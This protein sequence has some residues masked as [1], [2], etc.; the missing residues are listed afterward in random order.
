MH[1]GKCLGVLHSSFLVFNFWLLHA[2]LLNVDGCPVESIS[3]LGGRLVGEL[4]QRF[5]DNTDCDGFTIDGI[6]VFRRAKG[7]GT[8]IDFIK[9]E[10]SELWVENHAAL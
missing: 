2:E 1:L 6:T 10:K 9:L 7:C 8:S 4:D 3:E 5:L